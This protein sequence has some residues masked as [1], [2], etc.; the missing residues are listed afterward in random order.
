[1]RETRIER[2][3]SCKRAEEVSVVARSAPS[4]EALTF[5][6]VGVSSLSLPPCSQPMVSTGATICS[7]VGQGQ[8]HAILVSRAASL[9]VSLCFR[10]AS[11]CSRHLFGS[12]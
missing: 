6:L 4:P 5:S 2:R 9:T 12:G 7:E 11:Y 8:L 10:I 1:M 3:L